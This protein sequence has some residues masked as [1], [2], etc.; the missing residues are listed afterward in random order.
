MNIL[1]GSSTWI[2]MSGILLYDSSILLVLQYNV[3]FPSIVQ[4][5][6]GNDQVKS[7]F[8]SIKKCIQQGRTEHGP[9]SGLI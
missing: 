3:G 2:N 4:T 7:I 5:R 6:P 9:V 1:L 8:N